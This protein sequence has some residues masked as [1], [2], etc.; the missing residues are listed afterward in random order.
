MHRIG[1]NS[2]ERMV[3]KNTCLALHQ[4]EVL[5]LLFVS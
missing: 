2:T 1:T 4:R 3:Y 5:R